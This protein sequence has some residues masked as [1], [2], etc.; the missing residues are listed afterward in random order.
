MSYKSGNR[1][2]LS[3]LDFTD[4]SRTEIANQFLGTLERGMHGIC[5][6]P[7]EEGQ[8][9]GDQL[10]EEQVRRRLKII[11]PFSNWIR[12]FS[13]TEG[14]ELIPKIAREMGLKTLVGAWLGKD[15]EKNEA[16][17][18]GL[19]ELA[20]EGLV[21]IAAVGNEVLYRNDLDEATLLAA[22]QRVRAAV[23]AGVPVGY[24]DA[25]YE[26]RD[27]PQVADACDL[28]L[29]NCYPYWEGC[30]LEYSLVYMKDMYQQ[31][32]KAAKGKKV[33]VTETGW[34]SQGKGLDGAHPSELNAMK[35][36]INA[37]RWSAEEQIDLFYFSSFD[38][39]WKVGA[40]GDV[41]AYWGIW[42]KNE[43]LK[44]V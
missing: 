3:G 43:E 19:I 39:S 21:D 20:Q 33:I 7:Y 30:A 6:S 32:L 44:Y 13:C 26:F 37:Q 27:H 34:P 4:Q 12:S 24:V 22:I 23:P 31:A 41:G 25:Y 40:E 18:A 14:N 10:T 11:Q 15:A 16:E 2:A 35:Y 5:M 38:E 42:D 8:Q 1:L 28:I 17:I 9:P 36:F 29:A